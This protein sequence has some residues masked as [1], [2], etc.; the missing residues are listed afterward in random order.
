MP[1]ISGLRR[2]GYTA[3]SIRD[4]CERAGIAKR[5]NVTDVKLA[6]SFVCVKI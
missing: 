5:E 2:R 4:F 6:W 1:T 3:E